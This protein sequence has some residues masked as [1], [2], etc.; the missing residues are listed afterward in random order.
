MTAPRLSRRTVLRGAGAALALPWLEAMQPALVR[1]ASRTAG[2]RPIRLAA[3][4]FP[5]G[6][7]EEKWTPETTGYD[8]TPPAQ[9]MPLEG[10]KSEVSVV[11]GLW[12]EATNTGD[13]HYVK[14]AAWL[15]G[16]T[17][18]KTTG[19]DLNSGGVSMD[20]V[21]AATLGQHTPLPS[22]ELGAEPV[23]SG[24]DAAVGY[25]RVY[26]AH[27][28]W[29]QP[30]QPL[31]KEINPRLV[32][33]R[34]TTV[35]AG[36]PAGRSNRSLLDLVGEDARR[37]R[38]QLGQNDQRRLDEYLESVHALETRLERAEAPAANPWKSRVDFSTRQPPADSPADHAERTRLMLDMIA[39]AFESD[40]T[41]V[42]TF[43]FGN[44]VSTANFSFL[45]G[46]ESAHHETS[47][48]S[49]KP[50]LLDQYEKITTWHV[51]Q[52]AYLMH[53][54]QSLPEG[55]SNVLAHSAILF[56]S[57]FRDGNKHDPH[58][59][60]LLVGGRAGG[61]LAAGKHVACTR[62]NPMA[63]LLL[64]MLQA[65]DVPATHFA[66]STGVI[67]GLLS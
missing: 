46:V 56:G 53:K 18:R 45:E 10:V 12:H 1:A 26:G 37:L 62:D 33:D 20:Q 36:R 24:I 11:S 58:D 66:D 3:L 13:G 9:L 17:I 31:A 65:A 8:W 35:A 44:S 41:R 42:V 59:L 4:F 34:M 67:D 27:I 23:R 28:A 55:E 15:T 49:D 54:L 52:F 63:D 50:E 29:R 14:D 61:R 51:A 32:F 60:P 22:L 2:D 6:V 64:T 43:M 57:G 48:H 19:V 40:V 39:L 5:N 30:T 21:A 25:T 38:L 16:T 47:H 7:R